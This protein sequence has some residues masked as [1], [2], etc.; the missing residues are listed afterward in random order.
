MIL[1]RN[2]LRRTS[3]ALLLRLVAV[4]AGSTSPLGDVIAEDS[5]AT[6]K[7][8]AISEPLPFGQSPVDYKSAETT[9]LADRLSQALADGSAQLTW[10]P[11]HG[12]LPSLLKELGI[13]VDSQVLV[14]S[15]TALNPHLVSP[16]NPRAI[17]FNDEVSVGWVPGASALEIVAADPRKGALFYVLEQNRERPARLRREDS[18]LACH[19]GA[20][21]L[22]AP[23]FIVRS[24]LTDSDGKPTIGYSRVTHDMPFADRFGGWYVTGTHGSQPHAGNLFGEDA[25]DRQRQ[26]PLAAGNLKEIG[27]PFDRDKHL[28]RHSDLVAQMVLHHQSHGLNLIARVSLEARLN[29]RSDAETRLARYL[30]FA[31]EPELAS[32]IQGTS[33]FAARFSRTRE[34]TGWLEP[35]SPNLRQLNL[36]TR[37]FEHRL[38][39]LVESRVFLEMPPEARARVE[40]MIREALKPGADDE[41]ATHLSVTEKARLRTAWMLRRST[42]ESRD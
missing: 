18:C 11:G 33:E 1:A 41:L 9:D 25:P 30:L 13:E 12:Y 7:A 37:L 22:H 14:F 4:L 31:D 16:K 38:S 19:V 2:S 15:K 40:R 23:G 26:E 6:P 8:I 5:A 20:T 10:T 42:A 32:P 39:Y 17:Y 21:T 29:R 24:F 34:S 27:P 28:S 36:Q 3:L 35:Q